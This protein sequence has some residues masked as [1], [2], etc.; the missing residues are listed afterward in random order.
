MKFR[1]IPLEVEAV[2]FNKE[3]DHSAVQLSGWDDAGNPLYTV[4]SKQGRVS[5]Y[6]GDWIITEVDGSGHYP[7]HPDVFLKKYEAIP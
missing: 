6:L 3:G 7:C 1:S 2:P 5:V 4:R